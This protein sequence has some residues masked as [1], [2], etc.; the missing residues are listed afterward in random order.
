MCFFLTE[1]TFTNHKSLILNMFLGESLSAIFIHEIH[2]SFSSFLGGPFLRLFGNILLNMSSTCFSPLSDDLSRAKFDCFLQ[3]ESSDFLGS[4]TKEHAEKLLLSAGLGMGEGSGLDLGERIVVIVVPLS[5]EI[6]IVVLSE[7]IVIII[8]GEIILVIV[9]SEFILIIVLGEL[10]L[11]IV[12]GEFIIVIVLG[13]ILIVIVLSEIIIVIVLSELILIIVLSEFII[14]I[15]G[16]VDLSEIIII[17]IL[18]LSH[19]L[20]IIPVSSLLFGGKEGSLS[21]TQKGE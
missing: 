21:G 3:K 6:I 19:L 9:L 8:L 2:G 5:E 12:L 10:I 18:D 11:I 7:V 13:E 14:V 15:V 20:V 1:P 4:E 16:T 17:I